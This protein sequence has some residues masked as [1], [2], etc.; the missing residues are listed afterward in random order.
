MVLKYLFIDERKQHFKKVVWIQFKLK[1]K[2]SS[3]KDLRSVVLC[4][5]WRHTP[6]Y[7]ILKLQPERSSEED[8][9]FADTCAAVHRLL[10]SGQ[11]LFNGR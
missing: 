3:K 6:A 11:K 2:C 5:A 10:L 8:V 1:Q 4:R 9:L 7:L